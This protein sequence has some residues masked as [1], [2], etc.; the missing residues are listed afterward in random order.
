MTL[1][2]SPEA[3]AE[4]RKRLHAGDAALIMS[5]EWPLLW[6]RKMGIEPE[7]DLSSEFRVQ[8]GSFT[9][10]FNL[11]WTM[12]ETGR[13]IEYFSGAA[14]IPYVWN[15]LTGKMCR[16]DE[17]QIHRVY[18]WLACNLDGMTTTPQGERCVID[19][20]H[21]ARADEAM[22]ARYT[23]AGVHQATVMETD[24]WA[25]SVI[26]GNKW[27]PPIYQQVDPMFQADYLARAQMFWSYVKSGEE[28]PDMT[29]EQTPKPQPRLRNV[30]LEDEWRAEWPNWGAEMVR[31][32]EDAASTY[33]AWA[34]HNILKDD[35]KKLL[36]ED[37]G[38]VT[39]GLVKLSRDRAG[40][41]R[42]SI[43][44]A[45]EDDDA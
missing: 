25:L 20:K 45:K 19:A 28:P 24:W 27:L 36:P 9:E 23:P 12:R 7:D 21:V 34:K 6:R 41:V 43:K 17:L 29:P 38:T 35:M 10:P 11:Y 1:G 26:A 32:F 3:V 14:L 37:V 31:L 13:E 5:G 40:A 18:P 15:L 16:Q 8:L 2:L 44:K 30:Q 39:R 42:W 4:R 22:I 33:G